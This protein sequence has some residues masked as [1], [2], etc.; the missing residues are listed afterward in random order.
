MPVPYNTGTI[1]TGPDLILGTAG[2]P[3][4]ATST[5][6]LNGVIVCAHP[7]N[8]GY[9]Y[10]GGSNVSLLG[11]RRGLMLAP[12]GMSPEPLKIANLQEIWM[13]GDTAANSIGFLLI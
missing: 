5:A 8:S 11:N 13:D 2:V 9:C 3:V 7:D 6:V 4:Q 12:G 10:V 1:V